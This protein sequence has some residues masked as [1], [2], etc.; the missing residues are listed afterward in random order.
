M[1]NE[2]IKEIRA[3]HERLGKLLSQMESAQPAYEVQPDP[4][5]GKSVE[6][7]I[8]GA[9]TGLNY[10]KQNLWYCTVT[11]IWG[12]AAN[13]QRPIPH[14][15]HRVAERTVGKFYL[16]EGCSGDL[17]T[18]FALYLGNSYVQWSHRAN[19]PIFTGIHLNTLSMYEV[20]PTEL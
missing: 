10:G 5:E 4:L 16:V 2:T 7:F 20:T 13:S 3:A 14:H 1:N 15:L 6:S 8:Q 17:P 19:T 9:E 18:S 12:I 11:T